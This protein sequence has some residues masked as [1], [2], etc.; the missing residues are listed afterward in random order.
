[1]MP[2][3]FQTEGLEGFVFGW[4][5]ALGQ[6]TTALLGAK[7]CR[8]GGWDGANQVAWEVDWQVRDTP[9]ANGC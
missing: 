1:M 6:D 4:K 3:P 2:P 9:Q 7:G 5:G 8:R